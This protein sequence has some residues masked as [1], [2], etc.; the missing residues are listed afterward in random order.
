MKAATASAGTVQVAFALPVTD[1]REARG[2][3]YTLVETEDGDDGFGFRLVRLRF[4]VRV[5]VF[6]TP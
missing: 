2:A 4:R 3:Q 1:P 5:R 6:R